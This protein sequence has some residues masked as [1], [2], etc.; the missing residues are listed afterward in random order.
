MFY[1]LL[2]PFS[3]NWRDVVIFSITA[4]IFA[5][6]T[7]VI[8][9]KYLHL[10]SVYL[11]VSIARAKS[12]CALLFCTWVIWAYKLL[13]ISKFKKQVVLFSDLCVRE[14]RCY[15]NR[16]VDPLFF[17]VNL[18]GSHRC[19]RAGALLLSRLLDISTYCVIRVV[20]HFSVTLT[21]SHHY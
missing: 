11:S 1:Y 9:I 10:I 2:A 19:S 17:S 5:R 13:R 16:K 20:F 6:K 7:W 3:I 21:Q 15:W 8:D 4:K 12:D 18:R 14:R